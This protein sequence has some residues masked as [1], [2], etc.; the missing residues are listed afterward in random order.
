MYYLCLHSPAGE[1]GAGWFGC[2]PVE[3]SWE[4]KEFHKVPQ[5]HQVDLPEFQRQVA[6]WK[7]V[8]FPLENPAYQIPEHNHKHKSVNGV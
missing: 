7:V 3:A 6:G 1:C 8:E 5:E 4:D 2:V